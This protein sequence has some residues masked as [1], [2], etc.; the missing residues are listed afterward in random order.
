[1]VWR[2]HVTSVLAPPGAARLYQEGLGGLV[3]V[4]QHQPKDVST[5]TLVNSGLAIVVVCTLHAIVA[6]V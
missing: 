6:C 2:Y 1:M 3:S 4:H 5:K